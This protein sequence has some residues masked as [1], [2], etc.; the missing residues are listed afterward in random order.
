M[1]FKRSAVRSSPRLKPFLVLRRCFFIC[2]ETV[3]F[4]V[5]K[6][7]KYNKFTCPVTCFSNFQL[8]KAGVGD[9]QGG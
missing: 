1:A 3:L 4:V 8:K 9:R 5:E 7:I 2:S 6:P